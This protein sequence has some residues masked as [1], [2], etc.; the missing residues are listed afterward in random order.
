M[1]K[2]LNDNPEVILSY[3]LQLSL[4]LFRVIRNLNVLLFVTVLM[5]MRGVT[6]V[7]SLAPSMR[8]ITC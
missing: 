5:E 4:S 2:K 8:M 7:D 1:T 3:T 6:W